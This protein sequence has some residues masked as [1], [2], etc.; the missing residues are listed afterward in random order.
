MLCLLCTMLASD[1]KIKLV[2]ATARRSTRKPP[3]QTRMSMTHID[4]GRHVFDGLIS[5]QSLGANEINK[6]QN[7]SPRF[8]RAASWS[9]VFNIHERLRRPKWRLAHHVKSDL[10]KRCCDDHCYVLDLSLASLQSVDKGWWLLSNSSRYRCSAD[11]L[12]HPLVL[13]EAFV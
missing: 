11:E 12:V 5:L 9:G 6:I 1:D 2:T 13:T 3:A 7:L 4:G 10:S 8:G